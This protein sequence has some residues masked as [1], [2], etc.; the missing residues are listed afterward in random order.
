[1]RHWLLFCCLLCSVPLRAAEIILS[2]A[3]DNPAIRAFS[4]ALAKLRPQD[5][6]QFKPLAQLPNP[7]K[8]PA[9]TR[10]ILLDL[11]ALPRDDGSLFPR[12]FRGDWRRCQGWPRGVT[13][14]VTRLGDRP[15][16]GFDRTRITKCCGWMTVK[17]CNIK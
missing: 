6:V 2:G 5:R 8:I 3:D 10:L 15:G 17:L 12:R 13:R 11:Q 14:P 1:M 4:S 9:D 16:A 7:E